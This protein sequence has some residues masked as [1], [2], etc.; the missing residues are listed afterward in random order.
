MG[1]LD[2]NAGAVAGLRIAARRAAMGEVDEDLE[3]LADNLV[4]LFAADARDQ[5]HAAG[6]VLIARMIETLGCRKA[7]TI[8]R[9][10][11][12]YLLLRNKVVL[13][14]QLW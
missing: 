9:C 12:G 5:A 14:V 13:Q 8:I 6:I 11:H 4:A 2:Q 3:A 7:M 1:N 10:L